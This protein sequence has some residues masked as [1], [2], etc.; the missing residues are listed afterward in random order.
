MKPLFITLVVLTFIVL[1]LCLG[2]TSAQRY[3][4]RRCCWLAIGCIICVSITVLT[5]SF[6][7]FMVADQLQDLSSHPFQ[8]LL[9]IATAIGVASAVL[10]VLRFMAREAWKVFLESRNEP[11]SWGAPPPLPNSQPPAPN[12]PK[13]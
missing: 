4:L 5:V 2:L 3:S 9:S 1:G 10:F 8:S 7:I 13:P 6:A 12:P 11:P